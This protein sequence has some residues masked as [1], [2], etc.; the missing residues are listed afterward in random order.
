MPTVMIIGASRGIG[1]EFARQYAEVGWTVLAT[2]RTPSESGHRGDLAGDIHP[3]RRSLGLHGGGQR[4]RAESHHAGAH[5][6]CA[7]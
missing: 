2:T 7:K 3:R 6:Q 5:T 1:L 4:G